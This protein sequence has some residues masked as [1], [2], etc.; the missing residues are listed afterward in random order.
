MR[1]IHELCPSPVPITLTTHKEAL[2][3]AEQYNYN[4]FDSLILAAALEANCS[5]L[6]SED[7]RDGQVIEGLT[8]RNPFSSNAPRAT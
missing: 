4:I 2:R 8:I 5:T 7:M 6:F 3:M 1:A